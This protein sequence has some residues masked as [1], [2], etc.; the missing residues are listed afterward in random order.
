MA[1]MLKQKGIR[2]SVVTTASYYRTYESL[3]ET[4]DGD[5]FLM[6]GDF[7]DEMFGFICYGTPKM[8]V[9]IADNIVSGYFKEPLVKGG[10]C[11]TDGD[12]LSDSE[13]VDWYNVKEVLE[14]GTYELY[15][16]KELCQKSRLWF[17]EVEDYAGGES[18]PL[19]EL[20]GDI[21][22]I[23]ATSNPFS[24]DTDKDYYP[25]NK[26]ED[27]LDTN[28]MYIYDAGIND[29]DFHK[30]VS[31]AVKE[32][33][34]YTGGKLT[35]NNSEG[36][37]KYSFT[38]RPGDFAYFTLKPDAVSYYKFTNKANAAASVTV[39]YEKGWGLWEETVYVDP[40]S[41]GSYL[42]ERGKEYTIEIYG[43]GY[44]DYGF[45]AEQDNWV[46]APDG[47]IWTVTRYSNSSAAASTLCSERIYMP[48]HRIVSSIV[49][50]T[51][52][53]VVPIDPAGDVEAQLDSVLRNT[54]MKVKKDDVENAIASIAGAGATAIGT[55]LAIIF[56][57]PTSTASG[58]VKTGEF[59]VA[60]IADY[61]TYKG[62][63]SAIRTLTK[64]MEQ[65]GFKR[66]FTEGS[67]NV[68]AS[69]YLSIGLNNVWDPWESSPYINKI[70]IMGDIGSVNTN[71]SDQR[72]IDWCGWE[73]E[74]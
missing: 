51:G 66:A 47:G 7:C 25:D 70:S 24:A 31:V 52:G 40:D 29:S 16:W 12:T 44:S 30:G 5:M 8:N 38:R 35:V 67:A 65:C 61:C 11:D 33:D 57:E 13:E 2:T 27:I 42:L 63:P 74:D 50:L 60:F 1:D 73:L 17:L 68:M 22:V 34:K 49:K 26:D 46:Y 59:V 72:I 56:P 37:A 14:D 6:T 58:V 4:A 69:R 55:I 23:P 48:S 32:P 9:V 28:P 21:E 45:T 39:S 19:F 71:I 41:N 43:D 64:Y 53:T 54:D 15:T 62:T 18:N 3:A 36:T 20:M 10:D